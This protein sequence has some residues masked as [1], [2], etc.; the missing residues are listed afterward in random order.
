MQRRDFLRRSAATL[1]LSA[2]PGLAGAATAPPIPP[3]NLLLITADDLSASLCGFL[4]GENNLTPEV[5]ALAARSHQ[6]VNNRTTAPICQPAREALMTGLL[7]HHSGALGFNPIHEGLPTLVSILRA[8]NYFTAGIHKLAHMQPTS[9]FPWEQPVPGDSRNPGDYAEAVSAAIAT[10]QASDRPFFINCNINDPHRPFYGSEPAAQ[11][12]RHETGAFHVARELQAGDVRVP[13]F[14]EDLPPIRKE[15]AQYCNS[16]Q[17]MDISV[18]KVLGAMRA[19]PAAARTVIL[20]TSDHGMPFP[21]SKATVYD[22]GTRTPTLV[23]WPGMGA[24]RVFRELTCNIDILPT[25]LELLDIPAPKEIDGQSWIPFV[26][27]RSSGVRDNVITHLNTVVSG[28]AYPMRA[29]QDQRY[30]LVVSPWA[31]GPLSFKVESMNGLTFA[32]MKAAATSDERIAARVQQYT[33]GVPVAFYDLQ[34]DPGQRI[35]LLKAPQHRDRIAGMQAR[36]LAEMERTGDPQHG[37]IQRL[38]ADEGPAP[39]L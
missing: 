18:G 39:N 34:E 32:A 15:F 24:P 37:N 19:S 6:F 10:A 28:A 35:N 27:G 13:A 2:F 26:Q 30:A 20:F 8:A 9:C 36:L 25:V 7:P 3:L 22:T 11:I 33:R 29:I 21:F 16:I 17:R 14:L 5:D 4:G 23:S 1:A 12:D 31:N 38:L